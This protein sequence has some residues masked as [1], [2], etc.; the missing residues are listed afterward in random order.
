MAKSIFLSVLMMSFLYFSP[1]AAAGR[2]VAASS[3]PAQAYVLEKLR[4]HDL[5]F[6]G[7]THKQPAILSLLAGLLPRLYA[8]GV[9]H[10]AL[11]IP[12]DQQAGIDRFLSTGNS[13]EQLTLPSVIDC[14]EYRQLL[15]LLAEMPEDMRPRVRAVDLPPDQYGG[16]TDRDRWMAER[17]LDIMQSCPAPK[18]LAVM[19]S[20]HVLRKLQWS[21]RIVNGPVAIQTRL[22]SWRPD[23]SIFSIVNI[24]PGTEPLCDFG[25]LLGPLPGVTAL[26]LDHR[27]DGWVL[28]LT[29]CI[30][31]V[32]LAP[33]E[34]VDGV[35]V[36]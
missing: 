17:L 24:V 5:V 15:T 26:D 19:G 11:E 13:L 36:Y 33:R 4:A 12:S 28:G 8:A 32:P 20:L 16:G 18:V 2:V 29:Q 1:G 23:L 7:T 25:R 9:T 31:L 14:P 21:P 27:F 34:L 6:M 10:V 22:R 35:I 30:A 3:L